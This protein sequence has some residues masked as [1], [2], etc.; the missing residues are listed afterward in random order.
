[1]EPTTKTLALVTAALAP[2][3]AILR[4]E[5]ERQLAERVVKMMDELK[6]DGWDAQKRYAYPHGTMS[7]VAYL[8]QVARYN[9]CNKYT[10]TEGGSYNPRGPRIVSPKAWS[11]MVAKEAAE[12][13]KVALEGYCAKLSAK[14][15]ATGIKASKVEYKGG[16]NPWGVSS[17]WVNS[18]AQEWHTKMIV[19]ISC[20]GKLFNQWPT[21]LV[22]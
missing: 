11:E 7:R 16:L 3:E 17:I 2:T 14:I 10:N 1:M 20:L 12:M 13:A 9:L 21:R 15:D 4:N 18:V 6:L 5:F 19:N 8:A 22:K